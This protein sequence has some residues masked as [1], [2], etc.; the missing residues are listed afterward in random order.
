MSDPMSRFESVVDQQ[1][2]AAAERGDFDDLP[3]RG[4]PLPNWGRP[5]DEHWWLRQY[6]HREGIPADAL[7]PTSLQLAREVERLPEKVR[8]LPSEQAVREVVDAL[9]DRIVA[10]LRMPSGPY[11]P[12]RKVDPDTVVARWREHRATAQSPAAAASPAGATPE[13]EQPSRSGPWHRWLNRQRR[14]RTGRR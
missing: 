3:G 2:R 10:H 8:T 11:V 4:K 1:I 13:V 5:V 6:V 14:R 7:L 9:N 12:L